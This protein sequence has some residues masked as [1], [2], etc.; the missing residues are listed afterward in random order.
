MQ[1]SKRLENKGSKIL[2]LGITLPRNYGADYIRDFEGMYKAV[3]VNQKYAFM[4]FV[5]EG[6]YNQKGMMQPDGIHPTAKG[7]AQVAS[8]V[9]KYLQPLLAK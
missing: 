2:V 5:L 3:A 6:V 9:F 8:N 4:P 1:I 7:A